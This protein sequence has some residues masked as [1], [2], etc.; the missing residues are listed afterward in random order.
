MLHYL[1][2]M[3]AFVSACHCVHTMSLPMKVT[4]IET[5]LRFALRQINK[6]EIN[7]SIN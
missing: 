2:Q 3:E 4:H 6:I 7:K 5:L 1:K